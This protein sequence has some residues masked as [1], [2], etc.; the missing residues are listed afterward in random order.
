MLE[1]F[2]FEDLGLFDI[3][4]LIITTVVTLYSLNVIAQHIKLR[5][6]FAN[7]NVRD[8]E[9][10][11]KIPFVGH[12]P[13]IP[14]EPSE[15]YK[16]LEKYV[17]SHREKYPKEHSFVIWLTPTYVLHWNY[18]PTSIKG[19]M[20]N[21]AFNPKGQEYTY[22]NRWL[23]LG[24]LTSSGETWKNR[25]RMITPAF[26]FEVLEGFEQS[27]NENCKIMVSKLYEEC[28]KSGGSAEVDMF[29]YITLC[30]LDIICDAAMGTNVAA[31]KNPSHPYVDAIYFTGNRILQ[32]SLKAHLWPEIGFRLFGQGGQVNQK[33]DLMREFT[34]SVID[35]RIKARREGKKSFIQG[36]EKLAFL[37][38]LLENYDNGEIDFKGV[39]DEVDTFMF[40]GH[41]TTS[42]AIAFFVWNLGR[43][44]KYQ[45]QAIQEVEEVF[46]YSDGENES[47][48][49]TLD[50]FNV[51]YDDLAKLEKMD[52]YSKETLRMFPS[53]PFVTRDR[54]RGVSTL[55]SIMNVNNSKAEWGSDALEFRPE[56]MLENFDSFAWLPFSAGARNCVGQRF[57]MM[58]IKYQMSYLLKFF[59]IESL[60]TKDELVIEPGIITRP[61]AGIKVRITPRS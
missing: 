2:D 12:G 10:V 49:E 38:M 31:Q 13:F 1:T 40:E 60:Q 27:M 59:K 56:R 7:Q 41:D 3:T 26:H 17:P 14:T 50:S 19:V 29:S 28:Q 21:K 25:R 55:C 11:P 42:S 44:Q 18:T 48:Q 53:V 6:H 61:G 45:D 34:K 33:I 22:F 36:S 8:F 30:A 35:S 23:G 46:S 57:A 4:R 54:Y 47:F 51:Q 58:E 20:K 5:I 43:Y 32:R 15:L 39:R 24:L 16:L 37:D 52:L 9:G